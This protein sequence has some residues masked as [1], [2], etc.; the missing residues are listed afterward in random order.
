VLTPS[1]QDGY[2]QVASLNPGAGNTTNVL[3]D[4]GGSMTRGNTIVQSAAG[5]STEREWD[6]V[7]VGSGYSSIVNRLSGMALDMSG[8]VGALA[9]FAVQEP[10][11]GTPTQ[12]WQILP[13][14]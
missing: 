8:G 12:Q 1:N 9:G 2:F 13:V 11:S 7:S 5:S 4:S 14:H 10:L 3:D 6:F